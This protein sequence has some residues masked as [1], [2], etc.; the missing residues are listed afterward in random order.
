MK[1]NNVTELARIK[2]NVI[3]C[4]YLN[5]TVRDIFSYRNGRIIEV[6]KNDEFETKFKVWFLD[7]STEIW[8]L[9]L[10][11]KCIDHRILYLKEKISKYKQ[12]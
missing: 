9:N 6:I 12:R 8:S 3:M 11:N 7:F 4:K 10:V 2:I 5:C 1:K